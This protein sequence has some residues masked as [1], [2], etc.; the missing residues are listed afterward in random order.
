MFKRVR[1]N[2]FNKGF[3]FQREECIQL[4]EKGVHWFRSFEGPKKIYVVSTKKVYLEHKDLETIIRSGV[5]KDQAIVLD[6]KDTERALIWKDG[7]FDAIL[8]AGFH[9]LWKKPHDITVEIVDT[10]NVRLK[11]EKLQSILNK[12]GAEKSLETITVANGFTALLFVK[13]EM[14]EQLKAGV[15]AFWRQAEKYNLYHFDTRETILDITGQDIITA[16]KVTLRLNAVVA[17]KITDA[18]KAVTSAENVNHSLY[19]ET[20]LA[21]RAVIGTH[22]LDHIL[23]EKETVSSELETM[24]KNKAVDYGLEVTGVG[25]RDVILP[26]DMKELLNKVTEAKKAAEANIICRREEIAAMRSQANTAKM[27][28]NNAT[29]MRLKE[30]EV[31]ERIAT[32]SKLNI[33]LNE[34]SLTQQIMN[35][36]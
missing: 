17:F 22:D 10:G 16:D 35:I 12:P 19:R 27:L 34:K 24:I 18:L 28:E 29:L 6:L 20:Q 5:L 32:S 7:R 30:L 11:H 15:Y 21:L 26:G 1:I 4:L 14:V 3:V 33:I 8:P 36:V 31:L 9:V 2:E 13:G 23:Q 25:I